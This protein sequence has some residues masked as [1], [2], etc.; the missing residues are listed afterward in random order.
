M[1]YLFLAGLKAAAASVLVAACGIVSTKIL[2][3]VLGPAGVG[4]FSL[5]R[6]VLMTA[7]VIASLNPQAA[8]AHAVAQGERSGDLGLRLSAVFWAL[9]AWTALVVAAA[10]AWSRATGS[11]LPAGLPQQSGLAVLMALAVAANVLAVVLLQTLQGLR[12]IGASGIA[13]V[14]G[15]AVTALC[16]YPL[17]L[18]A[19]HGAAEALI[20][21][22]LVGPLASVA[23]AAYFGGRAGWLWR[24][25]SAFFRLQADRA[26]MAEFLRIAFA[27]LAAAL[28]AAASLLAVRSII[29]RDAGL[30]AAGVFDAAWTLSHGCFGLL[31]AALGSY[32]LP[33]LI[34]ARDA[35]A[36][37][38]AV[39]E[40][41][42]LVI[43][44]TVPALLV[45]M[46]LRREIAVALYS[47]Q[48]QV[49]DAALL[50]MLAGQYLRCTGWCLSFLALAR[51]RMRLV[52]MCEAL[53]CA[54][55]VSAALAGSG[56]RNPLLSIGIAYAGLYAAYAACFA[57]Y[58][59]GEQR[60][61]LERRVLRAWLAGLAIVAAA[62]ALLG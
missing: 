62:A 28:L 11:L 9:L 24:A 49:A 38:N 1:R 60:L 19:A 25:L 18:R 61:V 45:A 57:A 51:A 13:A 43:A 36:A 56:D 48:F 31:L 34:G 26:A 7:T 39:N 4:L 33:A 44:V 21:L 5:L 16:S 59:L 32:Y 20:G 12:M 58:A 3:V 54:G 37:G 35:P 50:W 22:L 14:A 15:G 27:G 46:V 41:L 2:A 8:L 53:W 47:P 55:I 6:Q 10:M 29:A 40:A 30:E 52:L 17:A 23:V 42:L